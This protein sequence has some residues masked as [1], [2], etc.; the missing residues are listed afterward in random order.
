MKNKTKSLRRPIIMYSITEDCQMLC[1]HCYNESGGR[2]NFAPTKEELI[3][4]TRRL[5]KLAGAINFTGGEPFLRPELPELLA[6]SYSS[7]VDNIVTTNGIC[8]T[9]KNAPRLL[10]KIQENVYMIEVGM[11]GATP[12]TN[13]YVRGKGH[14]DIAIKSLDLMARYNFASGIKIALD[15]HN[16]DEIEAFANLALEHKVSQILYGQLLVVGRASNNMGNLGLN[17]EDINRIEDKLKCITEKHWGSIKITQHCT[18]S[19]LCSD[20]GHLYTITAKGGVTPCLM[21]QDLARG[22][23]NKVDINIL[24][25]EIDQLRGK[26]QVHS[27]VRDIKETAQK[28]TRHTPEEIRQVHLTSHSVLVR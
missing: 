2:N 20:P 12:E 17:L 9:E 16:I 14:F 27:S 21:R 3:R 4:N 8:L 1:K 28:E 19:G 18:L 6:L 22:D 13:D 7:G 26:I 10:D 11:M 24:F 5:S 15:K 25:R 23:I